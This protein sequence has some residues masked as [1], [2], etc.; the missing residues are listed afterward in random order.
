MNF[1]S[2]RGQGGKV[3]ASE[4][5]VKGLAADGGLYVPEAF[6]KIFDK[7]KGNTNLSYEALAFNIIKE[8]FDD[9]SEEK[10]KEAI[11]AAYKGRFEVK[12]EKNFL[13]LYHGPTS[14]FKD[15]A[16]LF[17]PQIMKKAK[18][19][20]N[21]ENEIVILTA[22]SGDTGK[23]ALE[24]FS[25]VPGF[26]V[27]VYYPQNGVSEIQRKQM[28]SQKGNNVKVVGIEGNFDNAQTGV[29]NIFADNEL[30]KELENM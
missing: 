3:T 20:L 26:K 8:F 6:P 4:A 14:A 21:I 18:E 9:I 15:A 30:K 7:L 29:K 10:L 19:E 27:V 5:I 2:T 1:I 17:L 24:G 25:D 28:I 13:E 12:E 11:D 22:T 16:L 23:A